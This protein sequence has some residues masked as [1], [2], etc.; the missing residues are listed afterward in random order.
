MAMFLILSVVNIVVIP[1]L[2][3]NE[4]NDAL[5]FEKQSEGHW[6]VKWLKKWKPLLASLIFTP[7][8]FLVGIAGSVEGELF[9]T[10][11]IFP[12]TVI[13]VVLFRWVLEIGLLGSTPDNLKG[14]MFGS[15]LVLTVIQFPIYGMIV[16]LAERRD[17]TAVKLA[18][19]HLSL[20][21]LSF[22]LAYR[23]GL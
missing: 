13:S 8:G 5:M 9:Y 1:C 21:V 19:V 23:Y 17:L 22:I 12:F 16:T 11:I 2:K 10:K 7:I 18:A 20:S 14:F 6:L 4:Y 3:A 15:L